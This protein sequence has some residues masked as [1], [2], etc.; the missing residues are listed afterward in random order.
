MT[1]DKTSTH[2]Q[3]GSNGAGDFDAVF[4]ADHLLAPTE[5]YEAAARRI[6]FGA[7]RDLGTASTLDPHAL[8][9]AENHRRKTTLASRPAAFVPA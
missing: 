3:G 7:K 4:G 1:A 6:T 8:A 2:G 5:A 9:Y